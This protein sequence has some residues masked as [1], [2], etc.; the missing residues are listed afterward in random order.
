M[1]DS[2]DPSWLVKAGGCSQQ[3]STRAHPNEDLF[4]I[5]DRLQSEDGT[6]SA[7]F[8]AVFDGHGGSA[9]AKYM[10]E[11][12]HE[13]IRV[14]D[15]FVAGDMRLAL[16]QG[17]DSAET[18]FMEAS[19]DSSGSCAI[20]ALIANETIHLA[21]VGDCRFALSAD[22][23]N[24][25]ETRDHKASD[26]EEK[27]RIEDCGGFVVRE[28]VFGL[29]A[30]ARSLGDREYKTKE[31]HQVVIAKP[32]FHS[33]DIQSDHDLFVMASDGVWDVIPGDQVI[34]IARKSIF[35]DGSSPEEAARLLVRHAFTKGSKDDITAVICQLKQ[36]A[37]KHKENPVD[38]SALWGMLGFPP[39]N[40]NPSQ[41]TPQSCND[42]EKTGA[43]EPEFQ[44]ED[45]GAIFEF[46]EETIR[47]SSNKTKRR[48]LIWKKKG[49]SHSMRSLSLTPQLESLQ[50]EVKEQKPSS[51]SPRP[52]LLRTES[53]NAIEK[54]PRGKKLVWVKKKVIKKVKRRRRKGSAASSVGSREGTKQKGTNEKQKR[55]SKVSHRRSQFENRDLVF[56]L[57]FDAPEVR[58]GEG[59]LPSVFDAFVQRKLA[60]TSETN[61]NKL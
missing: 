58:S 17:I 34:S 3:C 14:S 15:G 26:P 11:H 20:I 59:D 56:K 49:K 6:S 25:F 45:V 52:P 50:D 33:I 12:L 30:V 44:E 32:D 40:T 54:L 21:N 36:S 47:S 41:S 57:E 16:E 27:K 48:S 60:E 43:V 53:M 46:P 1:A 38:A 10:S 61:E 13:S 37:L 9:C 22:G 31:M 42:T 39:P 29:L 5:M 19:E 51:H 7:H 55:T 2:L 28:R 35:E 23:K 8:M 18:A 24:V 4:V